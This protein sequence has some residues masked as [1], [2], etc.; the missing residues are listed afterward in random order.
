[1]IAV[2]RERPPRDPAAEQ[3]GD[4]LSRPKAGCAEV[5]RCAVA[6]QR[7]LELF[8]VSGKWSLAR[9][10]HHVQFVVGVVQL[11]VDDPCGARDVCIELGEVGEGPGLSYISSRLYGRANQ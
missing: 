9:A 1:M 7:P 4:L 3:V 11:T 5:R 10:P 2:I 6:H 8:C